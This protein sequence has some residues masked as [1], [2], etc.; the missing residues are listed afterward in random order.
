[1]LAVWS[2]SA[3]RELS[4]GTISLSVSPF[5]EGALDVYVPLVD[6]GVR[7]GGVSAPARLKVELKSVDREVAA[8]VA[9]GG[10]D[11]TRQVRGEARDAVAS[12]LLV[13]ALLTAAGALG[14]GLLVLAALR[15]A[16]RRARVLGAGVVVG[17]IGWVAVIGLLLAPRGE[18]PDQRYYA[19]GTDIPVALRALESA[20]RSP[21]VLSEEL[22]AQ[23]LGLA[24]LVTAP[25]GRV[26]LSGL[27]RLTVASDLHNNVLAIPALRRAAAGGPVI[28][29]GDL[30][31]SGTPLETRVTRSVVR[32]GR[33]FVM[34]GGNHDSD[35]SLR[36]LARAGAVVLGREGR[37]RADGRRGPVVNRVGG[38]R[39]AGYESPNLRRAASGYDDRGAAVTAGQQAAFKAWLD[40]LVGRIDVVVVHEPALAAPALAGLRADPPAAPLLVIEGHTHRQAIDSRSSITLV[41]GGTVGGGGTGNLADD[42]PIGLAVV[43]YDT[44]PFAPLAADLVTVAPGDGGGSARRVRLDEGS[45]RTGDPDAQS[46]EEDPARADP[47]RDAGGRILSAPPNRR[48]D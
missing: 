6:W 3:D 19:R 27:P 1:M 43:T 24:R 18:L 38:L 45:A 21:D 48:T 4:A 23:L 42:L 22:D 10:L 15:P 32:T 47:V 26:A 13:L 8:D 36:A 7:F 29:A 17:A 2:Y 20:A 37:L 5:H 39:V 41:N 31:D 33:P 14:A 12:Y 35:A 25:G 16:R 34:L 11:A 30:S 46:P 28:F 44:R 40:P 9:S